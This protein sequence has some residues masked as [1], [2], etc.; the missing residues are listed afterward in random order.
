M[1]KHV[2]PLLTVLLFA[3]LAAT[4]AAPSQPAR[5]NI[6]LIILEDW[7]PH[8]GCYGEKAMRT[9]NLDQLASEGRRYRPPPRPMLVPTY[10]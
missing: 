7:G 1:M 9:P 2:L 5:P 6:L 8:L 3:P 10:C 4:E